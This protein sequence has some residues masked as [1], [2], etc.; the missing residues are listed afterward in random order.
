MEHLAIMKKSWGLTKKILIGEKRI[1]SRWYTTKRSPWNMIKPGDIIYFKDSGEPVSIK[2][3]VEKVVQFANLS[4]EKVKDILNK[5]GKD[6]GLNEDNIPY[7]IERFRNK[8]YC[9]LIYLKNPQKVEPFFINKGG[10]GSMSAW[11]TIQ[12]INA[13]KK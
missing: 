5:Y 2:A 12:N 9:M 10:F 7:F 1:E 6:D 4:S 8:K 11:I 13:I 3:E